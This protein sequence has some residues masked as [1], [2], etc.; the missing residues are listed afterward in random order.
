MDT[1][2]HL[3]KFEERAIALTELEAQLAIKQQRK[4]DAAEED[5]AEARHM[6]EKYAELVEDDRKRA[7]ERSLAKDRYRVALEWQLQ[8]RS[9]QAV[10]AE[11]AEELEALQLLR[12]A[13][14]QAQRAAEVEAKKKAAALKAAKET[15]AVNVAR[16]KMAEQRR[17][18]DLEE[19]LRIARYAAEKEAALAELDCQK[20][21]REGQKSA[22]VE[23]AAERLIQERMLAE[24]EERTRARNA[25]IQELVKKRE[26]AEALRQRKAAKEA[27]TAALTAQIQRRAADKA[28]KEAEEAERAAA[29][30]TSLI[31]KFHVTP[32]DTAAKAAEQ[33]AYRDG[34]ERSAV[35]ARLA[36]KEA[37]YAKLQ[38]RLE[39]MAE[40]KADAIVKDGLRE[41]TLRRLESRKAQQSLLETVKTIKL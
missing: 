10:V 21:T 41:G 1:I 11:E 7:Q 17:L 22:A 29:L 5:M 3:Q 39:Q 37:Q 27:Y 6:Q 19:D 20:K 28:R 15:Q 34:F 36:A 23:A 12:T 38:E 31:A 33:Q 18:R 16:V 25:A 14:I 13:Q 40:S 30:A 9:E 4:R 32:P 8:Q 26:D 2:R 24:A 35:A